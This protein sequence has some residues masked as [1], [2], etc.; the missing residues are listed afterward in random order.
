MESTHDIHD[1]LPHRPPFIM[2]GELLFADTFHARTSYTLP[3]DNLLVADGK[4]SEGGLLENMAQTAAAGAGYQAKQAN[5]PVEAGYIAS[6]KNFAVFGV[7]KVGDRLETETIL[8][9]SIFDN[10][11]VVEAMVNRDGALIARCEMNIFVGSQ[12]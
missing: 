1:L 11:I 7:A 12:S 8:R 9:E 10:V 5:R 3:A 2:I 6:V 4:W